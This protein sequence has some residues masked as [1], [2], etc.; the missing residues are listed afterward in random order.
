MKKIAIVL[1]L[2]LCAFSALAQAVPSAPEYRLGVGDLI[3]VKV[4]QDPNINA[5]GRIESD[6]SITM[7]L[8][9]AVQVSGLTVP[10]AVKK[11]RSLLE[12]S[13]VNKADV[14]IVVREHESQPVSV[15]GAVSRP[16]RIALTG[17][18]TLMQAL[19]AAGGLLPNAKNIYIL[20]TGRS[21]LTAQLTVDVDDLMVRGNPDV[22]VPIAPN[23]VINVLADR[24]LSVY[25]LGEVMHPGEVKFRMSQNPTLLQALATAGGLTDR[26]KKSS[27]IVKRV[28]NGK[29]TM[30]RVNLGK[31]LKGSDRDFPLRDGDT[32]VVNESFF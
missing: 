1:I 31:I 30:L 19:S 25:L 6:G 17:N 21:G 4:F 27:V 15:V 14:S 24:E 28:E 3:E 2:S 9:G 12:A 23:D 7:P 11:I 18:M 29:E 22:N 16:G 8:L 5:T 26:A 10:E 20:R 32:I 13:Y